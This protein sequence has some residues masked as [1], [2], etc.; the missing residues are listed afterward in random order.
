MEHLDLWLDPDYN[1]TEK[2][3]TCG[4]RERQQVRLCVYEILNRTAKIA[5]IK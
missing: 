4:R 5:A 3:G 2:V 1:K